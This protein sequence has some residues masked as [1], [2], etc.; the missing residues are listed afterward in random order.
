MKMRSSR[1]TRHA[2]VARLAGTSLAAAL[3]AGCSGTG[4]TAPGSVAATGEDSGVVPN[5]GGGEVGDAAT[6][7]TTGDASPPADTGTTAPL[8]DAAS[9]SDAAPIAA[10]AST[11]SIAAIMKQY[12]S[13][14]T[15]ST[16]TPMGARFESAAQAL[17]ISAAN[18]AFL[19]TASSNPSPSDATSASGLSWQSVTVSLYPS[20]TPSPEDIMQ[21]DIGDCDGDSALASMAY[22]NPRLVQSVITDNG[23]GTYRIAMFDPMGAPITVQVDSTVLVES[24][25]SNLGQVSAADGSAD[26]ATILEKAVMKYDYAYNM[27]GQLD[28]IGSETLVPM[29][30]GTGGSIAISPGSLTPAQF[31]EVIT[32]SL[33]AGDFITGGFNQVLTLGLDQTV[34]A[35]GYAIMI[36]TDPGV[37]MTDSET[38]G[39]STRGRTRTRA[40]TTPARTACFRSRSRRPPRRGQRSSIFASSIPPPP[41]APG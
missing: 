2:R 8:P 16:V 5:P 39:E 21:H 7:V 27:V 38:P 26:W 9:S 13:G 29:F 33:A 30:T 23:D 24:G 40:G 12:G 35:H 10:C 15:A 6:P 11:A 34:T 25:S 20:G 36:P 19:A 14:S 28:G 37:D 32:V 18:V 3:V 1:V 4:T 41:L 17:P 22:V 31:Q